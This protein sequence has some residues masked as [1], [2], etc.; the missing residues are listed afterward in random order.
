MPAADCSRDRLQER[1]ISAAI[2]GQDS[3]IVMATG[4]GKSLCYQASLAGTRTCERRVHACRRDMPL[5]QIRKYPG[6]SDRRFV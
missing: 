4:A 3:L 6:N 2:R 1:A 5:E